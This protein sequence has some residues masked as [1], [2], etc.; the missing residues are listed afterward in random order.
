MATCCNHH[1]LELRV[2][3]KQYESHSAACRKK[4]SAAIIGSS[5]NTA[6]YIHSKEGAAYDVTLT[7][8]LSFCVSSQVVVS[9]SSVEILYSM[10]ALDYLAL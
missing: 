10:P 6:N 5:D 8:F 7:D 4:S 2:C 3:H 1:R 9:S